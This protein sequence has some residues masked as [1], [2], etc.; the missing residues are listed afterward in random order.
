MGDTI[1]LRFSGL[2][3]QNSQH[4][5]CHLTSHL[6]FIIDLSMNRPIEIFD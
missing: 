4:Q 6:F 5:Q 1:M 3:I 2:L